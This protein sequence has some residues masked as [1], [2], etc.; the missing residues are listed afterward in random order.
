MQGV[1]LSEAIKETFFQRLEDE[2]DLK[3]IKEYRERKARGEVKFFSHEEV[4]KE[5][6]L[7]NSL[8]NDI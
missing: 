5:L 1:N 2:Y 7:Q 8:I 3:R 4:T 6:E